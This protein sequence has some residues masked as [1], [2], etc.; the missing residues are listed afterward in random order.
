M[1]N[2]IKISVVDGLIK[3]YALIG[4]VVNGIEYSFNTQEELK[5]FESNFITD[6]YAYSDGSMSINEEYVDL[7]ENLKALR[8]TENQIATLK[9]KLVETDYIFI[10]V[11]EAQILGGQAPYS[12]EYLADVSDERNKIRAEI[13]RLEV[14]L[15]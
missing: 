2:K 8:D 15:I 3:E 6:K 4:D 1:D 5:E 12:D 11:S 10:K 7:S 13:N 9:D 14:G